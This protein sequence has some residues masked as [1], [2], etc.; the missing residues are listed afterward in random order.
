LTFD[1]EKGERVLRVAAVKPTRVLKPLIKAGLKT[2]DQV[3]S[4]DQVPADETDLWE[5]DQRLAGA[6]G[7]SVSVRWRPRGGKERQAT[8]PVRD[9]GPG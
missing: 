8:I 5:I 9:G 3:L 1:Y 4:V 7:R 2:G 6:Y